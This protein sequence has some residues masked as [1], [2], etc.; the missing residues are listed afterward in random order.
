[1]PFALLGIA[2]LSR[3]MPRP[4]GGS[5][6]LP[7]GWFLQGICNGYYLLF[8]SVFV[9]LWILWFASPWSRPRQF[10]AISAAWIVGRSR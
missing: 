6:C 8:F 1:M 5:R 2:S 7:A 4:G 3:A 10:L 9:G